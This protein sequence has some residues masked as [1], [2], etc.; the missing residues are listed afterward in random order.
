MRFLIKVKGRYYFNRRVPK[1]LCAYDPRK[2]IRVGLKTDSRDQAWRKAV[3]MNEQLEAYW[4]QLLRKDITP[5][6]RHFQKAVE[7]ARQM[8]F[9][10]RAVQEVAALPL[11]ELLSRIMA[12]K[13]GTAE[14]VE[15]VLGG[16]PEPELRLSQAIER[17][18]T[19]S[20][21]RT[22]N[23]SVKQLR[24]WKNPRIKAMRNFIALIGDN[25]LQALT[26]DDVLKFQT[27]WINRLRDEEMNVNSANKDFI[28]VKNIIETVSDNLKLGIDVK[29]LFQ[30]IVLK[31]R[32]TKPSKAFTV[33]QAK[34]LLSC[35]E[36]SGLNDEARAILFALAETG[37]RPTEIANL[38]PEDIKPYAAI[39]HISIVDRPG[40]ELKTQYSQRDIPLVGYA[41]DVF[42]QYLSG[43]P[44]YQDNADTFTSTANKFLRDHKLFPSDNQ[45]IYSF[46]HSFQDRIL[47][48]NA[49]DRIQAELMGHK[50][51]RPYYGN[52]PTLQQK[53][54]V[55]QKAQLGEVE[56]FK[57]E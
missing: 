28:N 38:Q 2:L 24:K 29:H 11:D 21:P 41:L 4:R 47:A 49:P 57:P 19:Y 44:R 43:F 27:W 40:R 31:S 12:V 17:F 36:L 30:K 48:V 45:T 20:H 46:R 16:V 26:R 15:A 3:F 25:P 22:M 14:Q 53:R 35:P 42:R 13:D 8:G 18:W 6:E 37:A 9:S 7:L 51:S 39:P 1:E 50:F 52:G 33:A 55:M 10:Y 54:E 34:T 56:V 5:E 32:F 23:K